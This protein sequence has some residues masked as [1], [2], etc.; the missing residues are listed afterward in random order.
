MNDVYIALGSNIEPREKFLNDA[1]TA[2][3]EQGI[4]IFKK[5]SVYVTK[6]VGYV[7]QNDFL[8]QV[9]LVK[10][11]L[12]PFDLLNI[13]QSIEKELGRTRHIRFGPRTIDLDVLLFNNERV[14]TDKLTIPHPRMHERAF[15][16]V[17]LHEINQHLLINGQSVSSLLSELSEK[18]LLEVEMYQ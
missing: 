5:S 1:C 2:L 18:D 6:P 3:E 15:V 7:D 8:N 13:C 17:P 10:T 16:L 9:I 14:H 4:K 12:S 11:E